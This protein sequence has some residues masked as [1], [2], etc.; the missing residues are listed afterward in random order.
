M[1]TYNVDN[2]NIGRKGSG[3]NKGQSP[4]QKKLNLTTYIR[5]VIN[6]NLS[7]VNEIRN[8]TTIY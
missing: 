1:I 4:E 6:K 3:L 5:F 2:I 7:K 8:G